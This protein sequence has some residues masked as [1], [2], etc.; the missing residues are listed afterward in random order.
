M[1]AGKYGFF[2]A[3]QPDECTLIFSKNATSWGSFF[4]DE[5]EDAL[6]VKVKPVTANESTEWLKYEFTNE[7]PASA[8]INLVWEKLRIPFKVEVDLQKQQLESFR[9]EL[10]TDKGFTWN[11]WNQAAQYCLENNINLEEGFI[12]ASKAVDEPFIGQSNFET[13]STKALYFEKFG[14]QASADSLMKKALA[15]AKHEPVA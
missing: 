9:K 15:M 14:K 3:V 8:V 6:R 5:K 4:Y 1:P 10:P 12:W 2:V 13:L 7:T 11:A